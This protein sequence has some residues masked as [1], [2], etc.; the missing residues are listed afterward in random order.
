MTAITELG[1]IALGVSSLA[2]WQEFAAEILGLEVV[3]EGEPG[4]RYLR[5]AYCF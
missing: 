3:D 4:R 1:Y 2:K 5:T